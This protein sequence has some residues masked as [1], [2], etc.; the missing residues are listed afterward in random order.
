VLVSGGVQVRMVSGGVQVR[1]VSG[2]VQMR[3]DPAETVVACQK[4]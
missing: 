1:M 3:M 4:L 2:G